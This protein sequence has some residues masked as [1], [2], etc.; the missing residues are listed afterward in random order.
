MSMSLMEM[1]NEHDGAGR[2]TILPVIQLKS[3]QQFE[4]FRHELSRQMVSVRGQ[5]N[6]ALFCDVVHSVLRRC[7]M[8]CPFYGTSHGVA[9]AN[10]EDVKE[11]KVIWIFG[12]VMTMH[13]SVDAGS[14]LSETCSLF[15]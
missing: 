1:K 5:I 15:S 4:S 2:W 14:V 12:K 9:S 6:F 7:A 3:R 13:I 10:S 11:E 8:F